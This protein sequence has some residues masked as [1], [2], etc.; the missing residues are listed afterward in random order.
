M[1][2]HLVLGVSEFSDSVQAASRGGNNTPV[3]AGRFV[4]QT[5]PWEGGDNAFIRDLHAF[6]SVLDPH[7]TQQA[8]TAMISRLP[9]SAGCH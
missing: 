1:G 2:N 6:A 5:E 3:P 4:V 8:R 9:S 7:G